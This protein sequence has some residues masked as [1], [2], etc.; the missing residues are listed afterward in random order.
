MESE[1]EVEGVGGP[2][3]ATSDDEPD[4][5]GSAG[6]EQRKRLQDA[7]FDPAMLYAE[8]KS[9]DWRLGT[10]VNA[11]GVSHAAVLEGGKIVFFEPVPTGGHSNWAGDTGGAKAPWPFR[12][13][14]LSLEML[15]PPTP[16]SRFVEEGG[17]TSAHT[18]QLVAH[19]QMLAA[20][21]MRGFLSLDFG[22][23]TILKRAPVSQVGGAGGA[24]FEGD[25]FGSAQNMQ[26]AW[27]NAFKLPD[28]MIFD[29]DRGTTLKAQIDLNLADL[30][31]LGKAGDDNKGEGWGFPF[32]AMHSLRYA[33]PVPPSTP[34]A[35][36]TV[37]LPA[38]YFGVRLTLWGQRGLNIRAGRSS[39][40][41]A[42]SRRR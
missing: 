17:E 5:A 10:K 7:R 9:S 12:A 34:E 22:D 18:E 1:Y 24:H 40:I 35:F 14:K 28:E 32:A 21:V 31:A 20:I 38:L 25:H 39:L 16:T 37:T 13:V 6:E 3:G 36:S 42:T 26:Q 33:A 11:E 19:S 4:L 27:T 8:I 23:I 30:V 15:C 41:G 2:Q 29:P